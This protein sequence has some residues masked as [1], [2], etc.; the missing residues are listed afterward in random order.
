M[1][2]CFALF[3]NNMGLRKQFRSLQESSCNAWYIEWLRSENLVQINCD[4]I[5]LIAINIETLAALLEYT[6]DGKYV[7][8][9]QLE[10]IVSGKSESECDDNFGAMR[11]KRRRDNL[12][13]QIISAK[14][15]RHVPSKG[16]QILSPKS[17]IRLT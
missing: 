3:F 9:V 15:I 13:G 8:G 12:G 2:V 4:L 5:Q 17:V 10:S 14:L 7:T 11:V 16:Y 1:L 6:L